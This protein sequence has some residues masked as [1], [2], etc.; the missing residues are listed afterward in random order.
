[1][2]KFL[3]C[4]VTSCLLLFTQKI[5]S[6]E[7]TVEEVKTALL[8]HVI[9]NINWP[10]EHKKQRLRVVIYNDKDVA[11]TLQYLNTLRIR[12][13]PIET[14]NTQDFDDLESA[15]LIYIPQSQL[16]SLS[17]IAVAMRGKE[18][19]IVTENSTSLHNVMINMLLDNTAKRKA[20]L[21]FQV[22]R[23]N[24]VFEGI[25]I[26]AELVLFGGTEIDVAELYYQT[27]Q[28]IK[29]LREVN[30]LTFEQLEQQ[31]KQLNAK[32]RE[33]SMLQTSFLR[34][35]KEFASLEQQ[36]ATLAKLLQERQ[37]S[38]SDNQ[39]RLEILKQ[40]ITKVDKQFSNANALAQQKEQDLQEAEQALEL[41]KNSVQEQQ[42]LLSRLETEITESQ[43]VLES[44]RKQLLQAESDAKS[45]N[46]LINRQQSIIFIVLL[47][48]AIASLASFVIVKLFLKN[49]KVRYELESTLKNLTEAQEQL[50]ESEKMA[51]LG[52]LVAGVAHEINTPIGIA[53]TAVSTLGAESK[54]FKT[55]VNE[56]KLKLSE[57][58]RFADNLIQLDALVEGNLQ[59][60]HKLVENFKQISADQVVEQ[61]RLINLKQYCENI[62]NTFSVF[63]KEHKVTWE[64]SGPDP[65]QNIDPGLL[66]QVIGNLIT[67]SVN[68]AF[69]GT[70]QAHILIQIEF[71]EDH[72]LLIFSDNG[73]GMTDE[74]KQKLF[75]PF[76]TTKR[77]KGG[78]GLGMNIVYNLVT[79][80]MHGQISIDSEVN[81]GSIFTI[82]LPRSLT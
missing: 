22:N 48:V 15:D 10:N 20:R 56:G 28:A 81:K 54:V 17:A 53:L 60:C 82:R 21:S 4:F 9:K 5:F 65:L 67:N 49:K 78:T 73:K 6:Q 27:E 26:Q 66:S 76:F 43:R 19:L 69:D 42:L 72:S 47:V 7:Y 45:Q 79:Y 39:A 13:L 61:S 29:Q 70:E 33:F 12:T 3:L 68:H 34:K 52:Q 16:Q 41:F 1:M 59:R 23:P 74:V 25:D 80:K 57:A 37:D 44:Q 8:V 2:I 50:V 51:S 62:M 30:K 24:I 64:V 46:D 14:A 40:Q 55:Q 35:E 58:K 11:K 71:L 63:L 31:Q 77:A 38:L 32:E 36:S 75:D 18:K